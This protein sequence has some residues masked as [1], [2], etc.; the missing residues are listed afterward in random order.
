MSRRTQRR[1]KIFLVVVGAYLAAAVVIP[2]IIRR[3]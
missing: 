1:I 3:L 2:L